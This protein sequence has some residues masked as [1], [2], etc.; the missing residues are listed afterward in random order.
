MARSGA[1]LTVADVAQA[2]GVSDPD[3]E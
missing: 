3:R 1:I 2:Y